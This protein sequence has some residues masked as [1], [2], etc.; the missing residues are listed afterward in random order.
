MGIYVRPSW[1]QLHES[2][3]IIKIMI[4]DDFHHFEINR[5]EILKWQAKYTDRATA[6][7]QRS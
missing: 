7:Y 5:V 1:Q 6:S 4:N 2:L 3:Q